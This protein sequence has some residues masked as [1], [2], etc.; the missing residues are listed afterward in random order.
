MA[1]WLWPGSGAGAGAGAAGLSSLSHV[2]ARAGQGRSWQ[3]TQMPHVRSIQD[4]PAIPAGT[5]HPTGGVS[6]IEIGAARNTCNEAGRSLNASHSRG[7][8]Q[9]HTASEACDQT[10]HLLGVPMLF[11][12]EGTSRG[13]ALAIFSVPASSPAPLPSL[14]VV[15]ETEHSGTSAIKK[16]PGSWTCSCSRSGACYP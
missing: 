12:S 4:V 5:L 8:P 6:R 2:Q 15:R 10:D 16:S 1:L 9:S 3:G 13:V 7:R 14:P 11:R